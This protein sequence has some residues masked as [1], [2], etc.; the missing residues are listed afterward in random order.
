MKVTKKLKYLLWLECIKQI[1]GS[2]KRIL[3]KKFGLAE[4]IYSASL[5]ELKSVKEITEKEAQEIFESKDLSEAEEILKDCKEKDVSIVAFDDKIFCNRLKENPDIPLI[6]YYIGIPKTLEKTAGIVGPR[7]CDR[8]ARDKAIGIAKNR[9]K[10][11]SAIISG[12]ARGIDAYANTAAV[13]CDMYTVAVLGCGVDICYPKD[14]IELYN[15]IKSNGMILSQFRPGFQ[16]RAFNFP[17]RNKII[18]ALSDEL[19]VV[20]PGRNSGSLITAR[21]AL[22]YKKKVFI[23][24]NQD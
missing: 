12:M 7:R 2:K 18:A 14:H 17:E 16:P 5:D 24:K 8:D 19:Y 10:N 4:K 20:C 15:A 22:K 9:I 1:D 3:L 11:G 21:L 6:L 13:K 23:A